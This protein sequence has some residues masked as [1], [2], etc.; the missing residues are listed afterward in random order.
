MKTVILP[1]DLNTFDH[2][3]RSSLAVIQ[4]MVDFL[5]LGSLTAEQQEYVK[6][7]FQSANRLLTLAN[8]ISVSTNKINKTFLNDSKNL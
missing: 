7:I 8:T 4:G 2:E 5:A 1:M 6:Y 3:M